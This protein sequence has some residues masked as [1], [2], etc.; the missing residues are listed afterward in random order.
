[1]A[2]LN[3]NAAKVTPAATPQPDPIPVKRNWSPQQQLIFNWFKASGGNLVVRAR[4]GTGKTTTILEG[5]RYAP[6]RSILLAAF[7]KRIAEELKLKLS[8]PNAEAKTLHS[9]GYK[10]LCKAK[11]TKI[12][13]KRVQG[14]AQIACGKSCPLEIRQLVEK[15][16]SLAKEMAPFA[17][18]VK[19]L[20]DIQYE[21]DCVPDEQ[22]ER[23]YDAEYVALK[24]LKVMELAKVID[25]SCDFADMLYVPLVNGLTRAWYDLVVIDE[26]QDMNYAQLLLAQRACKSNGRIAV[27]GDDC[28]AIYAFRGADSNSID[29]LKRELNATELGLTITYRC[30]KTVV[31]LAQQLVADYAAADSAP[32][33]TISTLKVDELIE[34]AKAGDFIL[35]RKNAPLASLCMRFLRNN[36][37]A[38]VEGRDIGADL[39]KLIKKLSNGDQTLSLDIFCKKLGQWE[40]KERRKWELAERQNKVQEVT[41]KADTLCELAEGVDTVEELAARIDTLFTDIQDRSTCI[42]LSSVHKAKGLEADRVF[43]LFDT[44]MP[45]RNGKREEKNI[46]Y[47]AITRAKVE[48]VKVS[49]T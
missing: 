6:E 47:V 33:G 24:A 3:F 49:G 13:D 17:A 48:L 28:Q 38:R 9:L 21:F 19:D 5:I 25:G 4:A 46:Q 41:D 20:K 15:L 31:N 12:D 42:V 34:K 27:V 44:F 32:E 11:P 1:M 37:R 8:N 16:A 14:H 10:F 45:D 18:H 43:V 36:I 2:E 39:K 7:N 29:R 35:S 26:A 40:A 30:P 22:F 23:D